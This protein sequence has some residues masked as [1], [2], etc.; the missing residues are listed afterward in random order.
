MLYF[1]FKPIM[2]EKAKCPVLPRPVSELID[3]DSNISIIIGYTPY[4]YMGVFKGNRNHNIL[5]NFSH[6]Y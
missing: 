2:D 1:T 5:T 3:D 6:I 4:E